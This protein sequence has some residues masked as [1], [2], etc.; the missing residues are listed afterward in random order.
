MIGRQK[1]QNLKVSPITVALRKEIQS[2][3]RSQN[4]GACHLQ[5][6]DEKLVAVL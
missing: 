2:A 5:M 1:I 6:K 3:L 4:K